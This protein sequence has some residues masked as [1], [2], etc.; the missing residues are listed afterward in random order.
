MIQDD[1]S[2]EKLLVQRYRLK[3][4][5][6]VGGM[7]TVYRAEDTVSKGQNVA[8]KILSRALGD[9]KLIEQFQREATVS[10][11]LSER[12]PNIVRVTDYGVN[13]EQAPFY[14]MEYLDGENLG[15]MIDVHDLSLEQFLD[16]TI[17]ICQA[18]HIAHNGIFS[19]GEICPVV[20]RD[21]K[22]SNIFVVE[23]QTGNQIIKVLD[24]GIAKL[25]KDDQGQTEHFTGTPKYCSPEQIKGERLDNRSDIYSLGMIMYLMLTK[26]L[27]WDLQMDSIAT[28]YKAHTELPPNKFAPELNIL[29]EV[30]RLVLK[31]LSK[32]VH[33]R[34]QSVGEVKQ[35]LEQ[36]SRQFK[37]RDRTKAKDKKT[38]VEK[39]LSTSI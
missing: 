30:E 4:V 27:P 26:K 39:F 33:G 23:N 10:A 9:M 15:S 21:L 8:V 16:F 3:E 1:L 37:L 7:G 38:S 19:A 12:S 11:L 31:C 29:P 28:W 6:G 34:P 32:S 14:V 24:F 13:E 36:I 35:K 2:N 18:M 20:H 5:V 22:P 25:I 17:Q